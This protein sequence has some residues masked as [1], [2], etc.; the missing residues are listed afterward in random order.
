MFQDKNLIEQIEQSSKKGRFN[1]LWND[2]IKFVLKFLPNN[3]RKKILSVESRYW[4][5]LVF[6]TLIQFF[7]YGSI[8]YIVFIR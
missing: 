4:K 5:F 7:I 8:F 6:V 3:F 2:Y 1:K